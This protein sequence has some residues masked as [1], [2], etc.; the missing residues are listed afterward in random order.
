MQK[1]WPSTFHSHPSLVIHTP[2]HALYSCHLASQSVS[3]G[4]YSKG[5][6]RCHYKSCDSCQVCRHCAR[7]S[8]HPL[9]RV[10]RWPPSAKR[11]LG[12]VRHTVRP[13]L[14]CLVDKALGFDSRFA[15]LSSRHRTRGHN[16]LRAMCVHV[17][18]DL[19]QGQG[20]TLGP[21]RCPFRSALRLCVVPYCISWM[22]ILNTI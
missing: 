15:V 5:S 22:A 2:R 13:S 12:E 4:E 3:H 7:K 11:L 20:H 21:C 16:Q 9:L 18:C 6:G 19:A 8:R 14:G 17:L 1:S 10:R